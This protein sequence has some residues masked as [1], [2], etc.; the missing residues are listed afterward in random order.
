VSAHIIDLKR[1]ERNLLNKGKSVTRVFVDSRNFCDESMLDTQK[2]INLIKSSNKP[3]NYACT[4]NI[5]QADLIF[6]NACGHLE[7]KEKESIRDIK[8]L[9]RLKNNRARFIV[10]GCLPK[11]NPNSLKDVYDGPL[12]GPEECWDFFHDYFSLPKKTNFDTFANTLNKSCMPKQTE[13]GQRFLIEKLTR[14]YSFLNHQRLRLF[15]SRS[16]FITKDTWCIKIVH[17]CKNSCTYCSD[18]LAYKTV[19]SQ[20]I[21]D[22]MMQFEQGLNRGHRHFWLVGRDLGSYGYD[23]GISLVDLL[24]KIIESYP[25]IDFKISLNHVSPNSLIEFYPKLEH[26]LASKKII[27]LGSHIQSGSNRILKLMGKNFSVQRWAEI[28]SDIKKKYPEIKLMTS[29]MVGFPSETDNDFE[30]SI[31]LL[32]TIDFDGVN[33][34][35]YDE[36]PNLPSLK[37][38]NPVSETIKNKRYHQMEYHR[39]LSK[40]KNLT[41]QTQILTISGLNQFLE[42][43][44][45]LLRR[46]LRSYVL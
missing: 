11:I 12:I 14:L 26:I 38:E 34:Y 25:K 23:N 35:K 18:R 37:I 24:D 4:K 33:I 27:H 42:M 17:G 6:Y 9:L 10:W 20:S 21:Q 3:N 8:E 41:G 22:I 39:T 46:L 43:A 19:K 2:L 36:R 31:N 30:K 15:P 40:I 1:N 7:S 5:Q 32:K 44:S 28:I 29:I 13:N 16:L 45:I